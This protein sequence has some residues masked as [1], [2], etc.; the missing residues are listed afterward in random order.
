[1]LTRFVRAQL[2]VF[3]VIAVLGVAYVGATYA[4]LDKMVLDRGYTVKVRLATGGGI[5]GNAEVTYRG[6]PIGR[7]GELR[8]TTSGME[9]DLEI[10]PGAP[11]VPADTEA[12][13]AN[14]SAVGEQYV[15]LRP[16]RGDGSMLRDG[17]VISEADTKIPL[18]VDVVLSSVDSFANSVPKPALRTV[19]DELYNAT[20]DAGPALDQLVGRGIEFVREASAHV[21]PVTRLVTDA[22]TVLDTQISQADAIRSFGANAKLL[23]ATLK[24]SDGD[25]RRLIPAV[26][27]AANEVSTLL[28]ETGPNLGVLLANLLTT[29]DVLETRQDGLEQLLV[30]AP[31]AVAAGHAIMGPDG[32]RVGLSLTFFDPP[33]CV[34]GYGTAY[35]DGLDTSPR[36]LNTAA[37]CALPKG[38]P[39]NV[40]GSQNVPGR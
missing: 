35:R 39:T 13:V 17:S 21:G 31:K 18:P 32:A 4:G 10:E 29:A 26:P 1:M 37:R 33:P 20:S 6:V 38:N 34:T 24:N 16:R 28:R 15:D 7:V 25:L 23:A 30:T 22:Q 2:V 8:L 5:F 12:V 19:V 3:V 9:V 40:R 27:A 11:E 14:R 36:P